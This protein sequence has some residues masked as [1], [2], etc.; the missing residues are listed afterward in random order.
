MV[1]LDDTSNGLLRDEECDPR[2]SP[3]DALG[4]YSLVRLIAQGGMGIVWAARLSTTRGFQK[5]YAVKTMLPAFSRDPEYVKSFLDEAN[6][7]ASIHHPNV[8]EVFDFGSDRGV[9]YLAMEWVV[10]APLSTMLKAHPDHRLPFGMSARIVADACAGLAAVHEATTLD[11]RFLNII[12]RDVNPQ[13]ILVSIEGT[14][15]L[16]DFGI[17]KFSQQSHKRTATGIVKGKANYIAPEQILSTN[18]DQRC[19]QFS[20][21]CVLYEISTGRNA[22]SGRDVMSTMRLI[23]KSQVQPPS[24]Y[25][26]DYPKELERIV[27][28]ALAREP[29]GRFE[30]VRA[31]RVELE[32]WIAR[33]ASDASASDVSSLLRT[34]HGDQIDAIVHSVRSS[35]IQH[36]AMG[37][38]GAVH[39][40]SPSHVSLSELGLAGSFL[41]SGQN[42]RH[43]NTEAATLVPL[44]ASP[45][46]PESPDGDSLVPHGQYP[47]RNFRRSAL[48]HASVGAVSEVEASRGAH[49]SPRSRRDLT[50]L[51]LGVVGFVFVA[52]LA[53]ASLR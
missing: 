9:L 43:L 11:G 3:G 7:A 32:S 19:D 12:H 28:K 46:P 18:I 34:I 35:S 16:A 20:I 39:A 36:A 4:P 15:K 52:I 17:A 24:D 44:G 6:V 14:A 1:A 10:G 51:C 2:L 30:S 22:F 50:L 53:F 25:I 42:G 26:S 21:G 23:V 47:R 33:E 13:N 5:M 29:E 37:A 27:M 48:V 41:E 40:S 8:C 31:M 49:V 45:R 38:S